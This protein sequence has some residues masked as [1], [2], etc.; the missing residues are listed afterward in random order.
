MDVDIKWK[1]LT[2]LNA[3]VTYKKHIITTL[4]SRALKWW[5]LNSNYLAGLTKLLSINQVK[6]CNTG[7]PKK[8]NSSKLVDVIFFWSASMQVDIGYEIHS[9]EVHIHLKAP[10]V[11]DDMSRMLKKKSTSF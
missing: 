5:N 9:F 11:S 6:D 2:L 7:I 3:V 10:T 4:G 8:C 1:D